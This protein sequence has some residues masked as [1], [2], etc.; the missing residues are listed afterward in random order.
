M[1]NQRTAY[2]GKHSCV[3]HKWKSIS[4]LNKDTEQIKEQIVRNKS[5][6]EQ[7]IRNKSRLQCLS[8]SLPSRSIIICFE[9]VTVA[10]KIGRKLLG[11]VDISINAFNFA[12]KKSYVTHSSVNFAMPFINPPIRGTFIV[13]IKIINNN[14]L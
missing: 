7:A 6:K 4:C 11:R 13:M 1:R 12:Y 5:R 14:A 2:K 10:I 3:I 9:M 8:K